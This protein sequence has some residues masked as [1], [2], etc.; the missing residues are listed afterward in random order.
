M[1]IAER[2]NAERFFIALTK[3]DSHRKMLQRQAEMGMA[4]WCQKL[5]CAVNF[6]NTEVKFAPPVTKICIS[7]LTGKPA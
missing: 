2:R 7:S 6:E 3:S 1:S 5:R 4:K